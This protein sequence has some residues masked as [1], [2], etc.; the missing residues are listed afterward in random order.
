MAPVDLIVDENVLQQQNQKPLIIN[1]ENNNNN[2]SK[3]NK[4]ILNESNG[5]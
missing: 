5:K 1:D 4:L 3:S 2:F